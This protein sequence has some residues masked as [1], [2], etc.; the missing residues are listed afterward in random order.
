[1][2]NCIEK[3]RHYDWMSCYF[4]NNDSSGYTDEELALIEKFEKELKEVF[5]DSMEVLECSDFPQ[6]G[7]P[8]YGGKKGNLLEYSI[9]YEPK[10][11]PSYI[12]ESHEDE[13]ARSYYW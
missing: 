7:T 12:W 13:V 8:D 2:S 10:D 11:L 4:I 6:F 1:M 9:R 5:G 3:V